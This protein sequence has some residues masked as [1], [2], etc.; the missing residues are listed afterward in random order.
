MARLIDAI[1]RCRLPESGLGVGCHPLGVWSLAP[2]GLSMREAAGHASSGDEARDDRRERLG[3]SGTV[4]SRRPAQPRHALDR[5]SRPRRLQRE[6]PARADHR[7][8]GGMAAEQEMVGRW[9]TSESVGAF[10]VLPAGL[11]SRFS[12]FPRRSA[13]P[14]P[15]SERRTPPVER[16]IRGAIGGAGRA[17]G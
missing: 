6:G 3:G 8:V 9:G 5:G 12:A 7:V 4:A 1:G 2:T 17:D 15:G 10:T 14:P 11:G 13:E 16:P